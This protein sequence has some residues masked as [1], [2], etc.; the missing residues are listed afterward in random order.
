MAA[1]TGF[2]HRSAAVSVS[3]HSSR[4]AGAS[5]RNSAT[6]PPALNALPPAP[7]TTMTRTPSSASSPPKMAG[8]SFRMATVSVFIFG[9][10]SIQR[11]AT[12]PVRSTRR[13]SL[14]RE[15]PTY[16]L[17]RGHG[18]VGA[19]AALRARRHHPELRMDP[20]TPRAAG[21]GVDVGEDREGVDLGR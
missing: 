1:M 2:R 7:L 3:P 10:R 5:V 12:A 16:L 6:S 15:P 11:V 9:C 13:N 4:S 8:N 17:A 14:M 19:H 20:G 21:L 18:L